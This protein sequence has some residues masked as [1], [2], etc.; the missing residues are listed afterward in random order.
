VFISY[1]TKMNNN[2]M[3]NIRLLTLLIIVPFICSIIN[4]QNANSLKLTDYSEL[5]DGSIGYNLTERDN[6]L[7]YG[8]LISITPGTM[9]T[10]R[11]KDKIGIQESVLALKYNMQ[12]INESQKLDV[13]KDLKY[14]SVLYSSAPK[15]NTQTNTITASK[16]E[17]DLFHVPGEADKM[18]YYDF[19]VAV[20]E[21]IRLNMMDQQNTVYKAK[22]KI[23]EPSSD[24][25]LAGSITLLLGAAALLIPP[26]P[27]FSDDAKVG[28]QMLFVVGASTA[29]VGLGFMISGI[30]HRSRAIYPVVYPDV[31]DGQFSLLPSDENNR[32]KSS[33]AEILNRGNL[34]VHDNV[35]KLK[36]IPQNVSVLDD[37]IEFMLNNQKSVIS[38]KTLYINGVTRYSGAS[39][40]FVISNFEFKMKKY[41]NLDLLN[42]FSYIR[43]Q[44]KKQLKEQK[45]TD[46]IEVFKPLAAKYRALSIKPTISEEQRKFIVQAN[47]S[48]NEK[49]YNN[50]ISFYN[51]AI[52]V[53]PTAYPGA[54]YN[55]ALTYALV[56]KYEDA[57]LNMNKYLL[58]VPDATDAREARDKIYEWELKIKN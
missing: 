18:S 43:D 23:W 13:I 27:D 20:N 44:L 25:I 7:K 55:L 9:S 31:S 14:N 58:L 54:Y 15:T 1:K 12:E 17:N 35:N 26:I 40:E 51:S 38:F 24:N 10:F 4:A 36:G 56:E 47:S 32:V 6:N 2:A 16:A 30:F 48:L 45:Y 22:S 52:K 34:T 49:N 11:I 53:E 5:L 50:A 46:Q 33:I 3:K 21:R 39:K 42:N 19:Q 57:V 28:P 29:S 37:R 41:Q 8:E